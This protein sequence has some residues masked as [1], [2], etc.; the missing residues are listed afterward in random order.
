MLLT[1]SVY[2]LKPVH[3]CMCSQPLSE[4]FPLFTEIPSSPVS[5]SESRSTTLVE[6]SGSKPSVFGVNLRE[7][8]EKRG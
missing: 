6:E 1:L 5:I 4:L 7:R 8:C 3:T 2:L